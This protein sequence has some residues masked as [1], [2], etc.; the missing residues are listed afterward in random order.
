MGLNYQ[1]LGSSSELAAILKVV[2]KNFPT[3]HCF[4]ATVFFSVLGH[5]VWEQLPTGLYASKH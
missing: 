4:I 1:N 3:T 2:E 5:F